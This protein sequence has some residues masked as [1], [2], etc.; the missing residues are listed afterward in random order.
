MNEQ[1]WKWLQRHG[2]CLGV[3]WSVLLV[4]E[5]ILLHLS[6]LFGLNVAVSRMKLL[7]EDVANTFAN[8][9]NN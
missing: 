7:G 9:H 6:G 2:R 3:V 4:R 8:G 5:W 1:G